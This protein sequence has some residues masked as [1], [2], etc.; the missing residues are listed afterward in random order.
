ML[1]SPS[2]QAD[3]VRR[4]EIWKN[5]T[6]MLIANAPLRA[7][8]FPK[9]LAISDTCPQDALADIELLVRAERSENANKIPLAQTELHSLLARKETPVELKISAALSLSRTYEQ[10]GRFTDA[11]AALQATAGFGKHSQAAL[12]AAES[13]RMA[14]LAYRASSNAQQ[15]SIFIDTT[16]RLLTQYPQNE[17]AD[18]FK[19]LMAEDFSQAGEFNQAFQWIQQIP[20]GSSLFLQAKAARVLTLSRQYKQEVRAVPGYS[21]KPGSAA[22][23]LAD[24]IDAACKELLVIA[25]ARQPQPD[26][27]ETW[28]LTGDQV[29]LVAGAILAT[30]NVLADPELGRA[31]SADE[32]FARYRPILAK[33]EKT[34]KSAVATRI[35][36]LTQTATAAGLLEAAN[37]ARQLLE[38]RELPAN[39]TLSAV[40]QVLEAIHQSTMT[41]QGDPLAR[42]DDVTSAG[43]GLAQL[44]EDKLKSMANLPAALVTRLHAMYVIVA[45]EAGRYPQAMDMLKRYPQKETFIDLDLAR[46][47]LALSEKKFPDSVTISMNALQSISPSDIRYWH[48]LI[49]NLHAHLALGSDPT[50]IAAAIIARQQEYPELGNSATKRELSKLLNVVQKKKN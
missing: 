34:S 48:A 38:S 16:T 43:F 44:T 19:L 25:S 28:T 2:E 27:V 5:L 7:L 20:P 37:L 17:S 15:R 6:T 13:A 45:V 10:Q 22:Q 41:K 46:A 42:G 4:N 35:L 3:P 47:R 32:L 40:L 24:Q 30:A 23:R 21:T 29:Q 11:L 9:L 49:V 12:I 1:L 14:W 50:Q 36:T 33:Y 18:Q 31:K 39:Q 8:V 26:K